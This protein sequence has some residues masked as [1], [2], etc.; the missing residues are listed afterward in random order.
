MTAAPQSFIPSRSP[1]SRP[2]FKTANRFVSV[3]Q[4][5][6]SGNLA[7][8][9]A[10]QSPAR[11]ELAPAGSRSPSRKPVPLRLA[12]PSHRLSATPTTTVRRLPQPKSSPGWLRLLLLLQRSSG[13]FA[14]LLGASL[15]AVYSWTVYIQQVWGKDYQ[16]LQALQRQ[17]RQLAVANEILSS[18]LAQEAEQP[19]SGLV[20]PQPGNAI[21]LEASAPISPVAAEPAPILQD[22][23]P[24]PVNLPQGY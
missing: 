12:T 18:Q 10:T 24:L 20:L 5:Y 17:E 21:F 1:T 14:L 15:L 23:A 7:K 9:P 3:R 4:R 16:S 13:G 22:V 2:A 19:N 6:T 8:F 11:V